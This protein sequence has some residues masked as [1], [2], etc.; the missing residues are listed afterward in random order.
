[1]FPKRK[2]E[3]RGGL[4]AVYNKFGKDGIKVFTKCDGIHSIEEISKICGIEYADVGEIV[5]F[6]ELGGYIELLESPVEI[7]PPSPPVAPPT[8]KEEVKPPP[9]VEIKPPTPLPVAPPKE[10]IPKPKMASSLVIRLIEGSILA[11]FGSEGV[12][13]FRLIDGKTSIDELEKKSG[14]E[15]EKIKELIQFLKE[16]DIVE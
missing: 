8:P 15:K 13:V 7:K 4:L 11:E 3:A 6:M 5:G 14:M 9:E 10:E 2:R 1:M 16:R 12:R